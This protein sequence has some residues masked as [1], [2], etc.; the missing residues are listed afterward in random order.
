MIF[1][2]KVS[3][4]Y[5]VKKMD[6]R[7]SRR[8]KKNHSFGVILLIL[9]IF[10]SIYVY[11]PDEFDTAKKTVMSI[12]YS[13]DNSKFWTYIG[14]KKL[15]YDMQTS[16]LHLDAKVEIINGNIIVGKNKRHLLYTIQPENL[17]NNE[18]KSENGN[19]TYHSAIYDNYK[20]YLKKISFDGYNYIYNFNENIKLNLEIY[21]AIADSNLNFSDMNVSDVTLGV[22]LGDIKVNMNNNTKLDNLILVSSSSNIKILLNNDRAVSVNLYGVIKENNLLDLGFKKVDSTYYSSNYDEYEEKTNIDIFIG[23]GS[24]VFSMK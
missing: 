12:I 8:R 10:F 4:D 21:A 22:L 6:R 19:M 5:N 1:K 20:D 7:L 14:D 13:G 11:F 3:F 2:N 17:M 16:A 9:G 23:I 24:V 18:L 15:F